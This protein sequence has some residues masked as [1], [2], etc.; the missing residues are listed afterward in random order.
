VKPRLFLL[1]FSL[2]VLTGGC[3]SASL[4]PTPTTPPEQ[5][6]QQ[7]FLQLV[8]ELIN[9]QTPAKLLSLERLYPQSQTTAHARTLTDAFFKLQQ[10]SAQMQKDKNRCQQEKD[11][12]TK[13]FRQLQE[14]QERLRKLVVEMEMRRR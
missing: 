13:D 14:D 9:G 8:D 3:M 10:Q 5:T 1:F 7:L 6:E 4:E 12:L 11:R 2:A